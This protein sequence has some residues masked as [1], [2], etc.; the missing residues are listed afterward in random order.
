MSAPLRVGVAGLGTVGAATARLLEDNRALIT[1]RA[2]R[3]IELVA[4]C[5]RSKDKDRGVDLSDVAW[6]DD[7]VSLARSNTIDVFVEL[8][9]G[10]DGPAHESVE[11]AL[12]SGR[13][14]VTANKAMLAH[15]GST[16]ARLSDERS[17]PL[18][19][20]AAVAGGIP[21]IKALR[22][23]ASA[24]HVGRVFGIL[25]GTSNYILTRMERERMSFA[26]ALAEAQDLGY[27]E[28]DP[29]FDIE[30]H[31]AAHKLAIL[32]AIAFG[33]EVNFDAIYLEGISSITEAD[34]AAAEELGYRIKL[35]GVA[36]R[37]ETGI[38]QRVTP[39][40]VPLTSAMAEIH[41]VLNAVAID[42]DFVGEVM[43]VGPGAGGNA[44]ASAVVADLIDVARG[45][46]LPTFG[47]RSEALAPHTRSRLRA[48]AGGYY[49]RLAVH[50][51]PGAFAAIASRMADEEISLES[52]V[53]K[54]RRTG[55]GIAADAKPVVL[56]TH[57][58]TEACIRRALA[59]IEQDG[60]IAEP[61]FLIRIEK[62]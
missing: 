40:M 17:A 33:T 51:R 37:T 57:E 9:G 6:H 5:A 23:A 50:D 24:N 19:F 13:A 41:G 48:H 25:N 32:S 8:I 31:D 4:V 46:A 10:E 1:A 11:A 61:P 52:I 38:E 56:I 15:H 36:T 29:T 16:L 43:L 20:E 54:G 49:V 30:G 2:G 58:T 44:T 55:D 34:L 21:I 62:A 28:A 59:A 53:Q 45:Q 27:A 22:E 39:A 35:L 12:A 7:A 18:L 3:P 47:V 26:D 14:V 42:G 60:H